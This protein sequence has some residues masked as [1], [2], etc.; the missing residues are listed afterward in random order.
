MSC[1]GLGLVRGWAARW[2]ATDLIMR[3]RLAALRFESL[4]LSD[5]RSLLSLLLLKLWDEETNV[6]LRAG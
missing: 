3:R 4:L 1:G 2:G 5:M 6:S